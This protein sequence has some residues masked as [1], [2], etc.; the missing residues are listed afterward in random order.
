MGGAVCT[1]QQQNRAAAWEQQTRGRGMIPRRP[2]Q[3]RGPK[4]GP[5]E[6]KGTQRTRSAVRE[7]GSEHECL[8]SAC[9]PSMPGGRNSAVTVHCPRPT[10]S[11]GM[12]AGVSACH[13]QTKVLRIPCRM[14]APAP[15]AWTR[16]ACAEDATLCA[17]SDGRAPK[18]PSQ[19]ST[20]PSLN[21]PVPCASPM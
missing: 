16:S 3:T 5:S 7:C 4:Q 1:A 6:Q 10:C 13:A 8:A 19:H 20:V 2:R 11:M 17:A 15:R 12:N 18:A 21:S 9:A 14:S